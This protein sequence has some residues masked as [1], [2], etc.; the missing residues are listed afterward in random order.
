MKFK[1]LNLNKSILTSLDDL[2]FVEP[3]LIQE[4]AIPFILNSKKD[5]IALAQTGTGK[6]AAFGLPILSQIKA[7]E[8][9]LQSIAFPAISTG[10]YGY[11]V[12]RCARVMLKTTI[13]YLKNSDLVLNVIFC[14][15]DYAAFDV[16]A[17]EIDYMM[18]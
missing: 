4:K 7:G 3:T 17:K 14:L 5:L 9:K 12:E 15:F 11:P 8:K 1:E 10:I 6:T 18:K 13:D 2:G 16:F